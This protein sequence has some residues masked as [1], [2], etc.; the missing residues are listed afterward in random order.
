M[1]KKILF[2]GNEKLATAVS[3]K[4]LIFNG[5]IESGYD[6]G[7]LIISQRLDKHIDNLE[8]VKAARKHN[9]PVKSYSNLRDSIDEIKS[10]NVN[11]AILVAYG[12]IIPKE[13]LEIFS[14][15]IVNVHPS[16]LPRHR[17]PTPIEN[18]ILSGEDETGVSIMRLTT[19]MDAGPI[20]SQQTIKLRGDETKQSLA[21]SLD[22]LGKS[23]LLNCLDDVINGSAK[24]VE[25]T[26]DGVTYDKL[27]TKE[28]GLVNW[29]ESWE[30][31]S[32]KI[33]AYYLWPGS[34]FNIANIS[35]TI[36]KAH[37]EKM[38]GQPGKYI[39]HDDSLAVYCSDGLVVIDELTPA[40]GRTISGH[41]FII[42]FAKKI[43]D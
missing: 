35:I 39:D 2:F 24:Q 17:G 15:G 20:Y 5:L 33:R 4:A 42:G 30:Q 28:E 1:S 22:N 37:H 12:K 8:V 36:L 16:I 41:E 29:Q 18:A 14:N 13:L 11:T 27:I 32:R 10:F 7:A 21:D 19:S 43:F 26:S 31:I 3:T 34:K 23:T 25:Q 9:I 38:D 40:G 6:I